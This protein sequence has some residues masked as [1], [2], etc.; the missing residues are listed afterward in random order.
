MSTTLTTGQ[1]NSCVVLVVDDDEINRLL[2]MEQVTALGHLA[3][4]AED[5]I[6]ALEIIRSQSID[7][8]FCDIQM[9]RMS[10]TELLKEL[11]MGGYLERLFIVMVSAVSSTDIIASC[12]EDGAEDYLLKPIEPCLFAARMN[13]CVERKVRRIHEALYL[14]HTENLSNEL[15]ESNEKLRELHEEKNEFMG[16]AAH[17]LKNPISAILG[18]VSLLEMELGD[19]NVDESLKLLSTIERG[20]HQMHDII[21]NLLDINQIESGGMPMNFEPLDLVAR[22]QEAGQHFSRA[23]KDKRITLQIETTGECSIQADRRAMGQV[24]D[25]L[26]SNAIKYSPPDLTV[27]LRTEI[28]DTWVRVYIRDEGPG[29]SV[30]DQKKLFGK[31]ARLTS[32][33]TAGE[34]S[35]GLGLSIV[36]RFVEMMRGRVWCESVLGEGCSFIIEFPY[37]R[38]NEHQPS[39]SSR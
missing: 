23:A 14:K 9:P 34:H 33:P 18:T 21:V 11:R 25:N 15:Q 4:A 10:G 17:D 7:I 16:I 26:I 27:Y 13:A 35:T 30:A 24:L 38:A 32:K 22:V 3:I 31:F 6:E 39:S 29:L 20:C 12:I 5:G 28:T 1:S 36:K 37:L 19:N 8:V 2:L